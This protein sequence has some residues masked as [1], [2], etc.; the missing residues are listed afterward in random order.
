MRPQLQ[1]AFDDQNS[2]VTIS[3]M[4]VSVNG[5]LFFFRYSANCW[6]FDVT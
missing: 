1:K 3:M 5:A 2:T 6:V 4:I